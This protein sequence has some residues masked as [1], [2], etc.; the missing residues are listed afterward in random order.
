MCKNSPASTSRRGSR[1]ENACFEYSGGAVIN[2]G[3]LIIEN[4]EFFA[5]TSEDFGGAIYNESNLTIK[6]S[7]FMQNRAEYG[8]AIYMGSDSMLSLSGSV[9]E[10]NSSEFE[11]GA[12]YNCLYATACLEKTLLLRAEP[13]I[14]NNY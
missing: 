8:G 2:R 1:F 14:M 9:F 11:G 5:N 7:K 10:S 3:D 12:I 6:N 13:F 4:C